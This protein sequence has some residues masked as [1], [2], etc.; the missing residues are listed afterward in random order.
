M[1]G[2]DTS[3]I[4]IKGIQA[5]HKAPECCDCLTS[6][7]LITHITCK[8][9]QIYLDVSQLWL[10]CLALGDEMPG[11]SCTEGAPERRIMPVLLVR[12]ARPAIGAWSLRNVSLLCGQTFQIIISHKFELNMY[13]TFK[14][15]FRPSV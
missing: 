4:S 7:L 10:N 11:A 8:I 13:H 15:E 1:F 14:M 9:G 6:S 5:R 2:V 3:L 12:S